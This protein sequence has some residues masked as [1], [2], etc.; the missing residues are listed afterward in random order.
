MVNSLLLTVT[1]HS[2]VR[3]TPAYND[4][5]YSVPFI[6]LKPSSTVCVCV[7]VCVVVYPLSNFTLITVLVMVNKSSRDQK[8]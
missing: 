3:T 1:L 4:T 8:D 7:C 5:N 6:T 2:A